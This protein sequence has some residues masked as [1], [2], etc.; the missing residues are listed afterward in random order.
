MSG[1]LSVDGMGGLERLQCHLWRWNAEEEAQM[2]G[3]KWLS[4]E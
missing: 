4:R 3:H 2:P 1:M